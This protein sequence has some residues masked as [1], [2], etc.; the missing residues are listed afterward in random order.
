MLDN[1]ATSSQAEMIGSYK[2]RTRDDFKRASGSF[3][4]W[5]QDMVS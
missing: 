5:G 4:A 1:I 3:L 2:N